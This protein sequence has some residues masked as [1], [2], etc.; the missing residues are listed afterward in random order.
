MRFLAGLLAI[1]LVNLAQAQSYPS[2][3]IRMLLAFPPGGPTDI[4]ARLFAQRLSEQMGQQVVVDNKPGAGGNLAAAEAARAPADGYTIFYN[5][6][7]ITIAPA[8]YASV[9]FD[10]LRDFAPVA[11]TA[12]V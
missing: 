2:K 8:L 1:L 6:S 11:L 9:P 10:P 4:N 3:P 7:A 12:T 5:T